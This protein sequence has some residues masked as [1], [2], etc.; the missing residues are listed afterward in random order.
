MIVAGEGVAQWLDRDSGR[1]SLLIWLG[2]YA[3]GYLYYRF[4]LMRRRN[5]WRMKGP[6]DI[7]AQALTLHHLPLNIEERMT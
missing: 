7:D 6:R 5:G 1:P 3:A 2:L 4:V